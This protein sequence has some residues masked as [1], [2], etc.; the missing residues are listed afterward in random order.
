MTFGAVAISSSSNSRSR[1]SR[2]ISMEQAEE[3]AAEAKAE[4]SLVSGSQVRAASFSRS[5]PSASRSSG[6]WL[7]YRVEAAEDHRLGLR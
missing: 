2:T 1:R 7:V 5:F 4:A 6:N 3:A